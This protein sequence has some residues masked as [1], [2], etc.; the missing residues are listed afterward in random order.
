MKHF[1]KLPAGLK[2]GVAGSPSP[3]QASLQAAPTFSLLR[4]DYLI[5]KGK[6]GERQN[7]LILYQGGGYFVLFCFFNKIDFV[8]AP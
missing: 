6:L 1:L 7:T 2:L 3:T 8:G 4:V 5:T